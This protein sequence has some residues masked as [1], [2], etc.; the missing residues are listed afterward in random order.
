AGNGEVATDF[1]QRGDG[2]ARVVGYFDPENPVID[3]GPYEVQN[4]EDCE[5]VSGPS[6]GGSDPRQSLA[7]DLVEALEQTTA[8]VVL[9]GLTNA[10]QPFDSASVGDGLLLAG[11]MDRWLPEVGDRVLEALH[12]HSGTVAPMNQLD[13]GWEFHEGSAGLSW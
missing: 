1:D 6:G 2:F 13:L 10:T 12:G 3:I 7:A 4:L 11:R 8:V 9:T 5:P